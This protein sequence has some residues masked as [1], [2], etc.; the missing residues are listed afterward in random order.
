MLQK[1]EQA[2]D[3]SVERLKM[4]TPGIVVGQ[5]TI[6][7]EEQVPELAINRAVSRAEESAE[8]GMQTA[9]TL[10]DPEEILDS[11]SA[12]TTAGAATV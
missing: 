2:A 1:A 9:I 5:A 4:R 11:I 8:E 6:A 7:F 3:A 12:S 10:Q